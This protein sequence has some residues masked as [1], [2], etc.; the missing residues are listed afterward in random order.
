MKPL[1]PNIAS[2]N[3]LYRDFEKRFVRFAH[4]YVKDW[5]VAEDI[6]MD[7]MLYY[8]ENRSSLTD[9]THVPAYILTVIKNKCLNYLRHERICN[10]YSEQT[11]AYYEW[12]LNTRITSLEAC[13]PYELLTHEI[14]EL[15]NRTLD[16]MPEKTRKVFMLSRY[17]D[18]TYKEIAELLG[19][20]DKGVDFH[21]Q[22]A[23]KLLR[24]PLKDYF[25]LFLYFF[26]K[27]H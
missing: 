12:E 23:L 10:E 16:E 25:P 17:E 20:T 8:W 18:K 26:L 4:S 9:E 24:K 27:S 5:S 6:T 15:V 14:Q 2:F 13:E 7:A 22:K 1:Q 3:Q 19:I 21:M 11:Q